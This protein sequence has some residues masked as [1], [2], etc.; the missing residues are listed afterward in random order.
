MHSSRVL[1]TRGPFS[2][3][4]AKIYIHLFSSAPLR[5]ASK[6]TILIAYLFSS[7]V[8]GLR[9]G[10]FVLNGCL[11]R[12]QAYER[13]KEKKDRKKEALSE[14]PVASLRTRPRPRR[15]WLLDKHLF[16]R[17][18]SVCCSCSSR[19]SVVF[20]T[21]LDSPKFVHTDTQG[22]TFE[23]M[24][25]STQLIGESVHLL[26]AAEILSGR[27]S[28]RSIALFSLPSIVHSF[29]ELKQQLVGSAPSRTCCLPVRPAA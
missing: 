27:M 21:V 9:V 13:A 24:V 20:A 29:D 14:L 8:S 19:W 5:S 28:L 22:Q 10:V 26:R 18:A 6:L 23:R 12:R 25:A 15:R 3:A 11:E 7:R 4:S 2:E 17:R 16:S 1:P